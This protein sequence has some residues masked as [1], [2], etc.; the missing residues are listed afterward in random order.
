MN[1]MNG[2]NSFFPTK[3]GLEEIV[4]KDKSAFI[5]PIN[6]H[7]FEEYH[8]KESKSTFQELFV[9][10]WASVCLLCAMGVCGLDFVAL[11][12]GLLYQINC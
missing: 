4:S 8:C 2:L 7:N 5:S 6:V 11:W 3:A 10:N 9:S 12:G 1:N